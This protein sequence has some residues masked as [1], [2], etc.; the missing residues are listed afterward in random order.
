M[1]FY[2]EVRHPKFPDFSYNW[3]ATGH[4]MYGGYHFYRSKCY[5]TISEMLKDVRIFMDQEKGRSIPILFED[6]H[7]IPNMDLLIDVLMDDALP[8]GCP[9]IEA[10]ERR[11]CE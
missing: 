10:C 8:C 6:G 3:A 1:A 11:E 9:S 7:L 5:D 2:F 4:Y